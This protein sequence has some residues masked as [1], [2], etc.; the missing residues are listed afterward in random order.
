[1]SISNGAAMYHRHRL[2]STAAAASINTYRGHGPAQGQGQGP[3]QWDTSGYPVIG[4]NPP[5][6][7]FLFS[8]SPPVLPLFLPLPPP[9]PSLFP[10]F[11]LYLLFSLS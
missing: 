2:L 11:L 3:L 4:A 8:V 7:S 9:P 10:F 5:A 6:P 1:M